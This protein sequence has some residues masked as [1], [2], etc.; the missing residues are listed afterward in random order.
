MRTREHRVLGF[1]IVI[2]LVVFLLGCSSSPQGIDPAKVQIKLMS[3]P[4]T[5]KTA[6]PVK[7]A[8]EVI[9]IE[10][11]EGLHLQFDIRRPDK[12]SLPGKEAKLVNGRYEAE[13]TFEQTGTYTVYIHLY[14]G[15]DHITKQKELIVS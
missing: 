13:I 9:G 8:A 14:R 5:V 12:K 15:E 11:T 3:D 6:E 2:V 1:G 4:T 7:L 10:V